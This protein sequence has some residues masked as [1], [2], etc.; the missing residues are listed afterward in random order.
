MSATL[1]YAAIA[2][3]TIVIAPHPDDETLG[4]GGLIARLT[5]DGHV[6]HTVFVTDGGAS[7]RN[8]PTW[9]RERL[10][11]C[12]EQEGAEALARLGATNQ[13][14][15]F[16]QLLDAEMPKPDSAEREAAIAW[17]LDILDATQ[18]HLVILPWRRDPH[19]DHRDSWQLAMDAIALSDQ[20]PV[21]L[22]YSI[23]LDELGTP[24]DQPLAGEMARVSLDIAH[25]LALKR[26]AIAAHRSQRGEVITDDPT[27][28]VLSDTTLDRLITP[29]EVFWQ[30]CSATP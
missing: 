14:R 1:D 2:G 23:W 11:E 17:L 5:R 6:V 10:A 21:I 26:H 30:P 12:R 13:P 24:A 27:G 15:S 3:P 8:S 16:L 28:F 9:S 22:E 20:H 29:Q 4:C 25:H 19:C 18:P 7:H